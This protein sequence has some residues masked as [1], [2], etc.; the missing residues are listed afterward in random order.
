M[1][2]DNDHYFMTEAYVS[3]LKSKDQRTQVGVVI[4][5]PDREIRMKAYNG[6]VRGFDEDW[7]QENRERKTALCEHSERNAIFNC[8]RIGVSTMGCTMYITM[9]PCVECARAIYQ[10]GIKEVIIHKERAAL[11]H[12]EQSFENARV[13]FEKG[14]V[15][16]REWSGWP[17]ISGVRVDGKMHKRLDDI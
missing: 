10:S 11:P 13:I 6:P 12:Y 16:F 3:A 7:V 5:G 9:H 1:Y 17:L 8:A 2:I 4:V 15:L 14:G